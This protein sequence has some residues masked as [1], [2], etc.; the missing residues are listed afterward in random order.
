MMAQQYGDD[1]YG[2]EDH[3][4]DTSEEANQ[5]LLAYEEDEAYPP[6]VDEEHDEQV[7]KHSKS[8]AKKSKSKKSEDVDVEE[9]LLSTS[10]ASDTTTARA[11]K[12]M[13]EE[14]YQLDYEDI[15]AGIPC[16]FKYKEVEPEGFGLTTE[17]ILLAEDAELNGL[18]S[19]R[20]LSA[21]NNQELSQRDKQKIAKRRKRLR[22]ALRDRMASIADQSNSSSEHVDAERE[23]AHVYAAETTL[24]AADNDSG[25]RKRKR[26]KRKTMDMDSADIDEENHD[27]AAEDQVEVTSKSVASLSVSKESKKRKKKSSNKPKEKSEQ[28]KRLALYQ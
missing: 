22:L 10:Q 26:H 19:L 16:R 7:S 6:I 12:S 5:W 27:S 25:K 18:V 23:A 20:R 28:E 1:Y 4:V 8:K 2:Y 3:E 17:E 9:M 15:V 11:A 21:Y 13:L 14:L 24:S